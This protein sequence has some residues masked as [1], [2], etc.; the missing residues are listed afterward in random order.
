MGP[1]GAMRTRWFQLRSESAIEP[2]TQRKARKKRSVQIAQNELWALRHGLCVGKGMPQIQRLYT[3]GGTRCRSAWTVLA[4]LACAN[5]GCAVDASA[6]SEQDLK[7][8]YRSET[9][10][11][12]ESS[13]VARFALDS[14]EVWV[15][16]RRSDHNPTIVYVYPG[17]T[18]TIRWPTDIWKMPGHARFAGDTSPEHSAYALDVGEVG[19]AC[20]KWRMPGRYVSTL[21]SLTAGGNEL[22]ELCSPWR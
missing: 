14:S 12:T 9:F 17:A 6:V 20:S 8:K 10:T 15:D 21:G 7:G 22:S 1:F 2:K 18:T 13:L 5:F 11:N 16:G 4:V 19:S 3:P